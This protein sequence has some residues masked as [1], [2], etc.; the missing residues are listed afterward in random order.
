M[1]AVDLLVFFRMLIFLTADFCCATKKIQHSPPK[2]DCPTIPYVVIDGV[3]PPVNIMVLERTG[4]VSVQV[5][6]TH[7]YTKLFYLGNV[8]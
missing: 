5:T 3:L 1:V 7:S 8:L 2:Q 6:M 4:V